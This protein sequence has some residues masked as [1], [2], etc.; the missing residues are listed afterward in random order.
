MA[1]QMSTIK[2]NGSASGSNSGSVPPQSQQTQQ[3]SA[4]KGR[5][6][7]AAAAAPPLQPSSVS[8]SVPLSARKSAGLDLSTVEHRAPSKPSTNG[9]PPSIQ[10]P[11]ASRPHG[12][13][14]APTFTP[15]MEEWRTGPIDY[16]NK[17]APEA[18]KYGIC[19]IIPPD[20]WNPPFAVDT[21][22]GNS[23]GSIT[24]PKVC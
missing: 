7:A 14:E 20:G 17:I 24:R 19:K 6:S 15:T 2:V 18:S 22:V 8:S 21:E 10:P 5:M 12:L 23:K 16:I 11:K 9:T 13:Q 4:S 3:P 1:S